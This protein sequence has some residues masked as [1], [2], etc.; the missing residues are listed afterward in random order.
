MGLLDKLLDKAHVSTAGQRKA[1]FRVL[2]D[3]EGRVQDVVLKLSSGNPGIDQRGR[4]K[5]MN[6]RFPPG[7]LGPSTKKTRRWH[8]FAYSGDEGE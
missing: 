5:F 8:D 2:L 3:D 6:M 7:R 1:V 4:A